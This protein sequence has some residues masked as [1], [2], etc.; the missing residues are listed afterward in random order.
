MKLSKLYTN[1]PDLFEP[2]T[3]NSGLSVVLAEIRLPE[4]RKKDTHNLGKTTLGQL[5]DFGLLAGRKPNFFLF[6]HSE[7]FREFVFFLEIEILDSSFVTVRRSVEH[8]SRIA[9]KRHA[10]PGMDLTDLP[11]ASWDHSDVPF[12]KAKKLLDGM[13]DL[14]DLKPWSYRKVVG[15]LVRSQ[16]DFEHVF[17]LRKFAAAHADWKPFLAHLLGFDGKLLRQHYAKEEELETKRSE[18]RVIERELG[19]SIADLSKIEGM[20]LL[21]QKDAEKRQRLLDDFDFRQA[22]KRQTK[23]VVDELDAKIAQLNAERYSLSQAKKKITASLADDEILFEPER[24]AEVFEEVG[25]LFAGQLKKDFEQLIAFN[26]AIT[27]ER[28]GYLKEELSEADSRLKE[29]NTDLQKLGKRRADAL[30]FLS[31]EDVF[32]KYKALTDELVTLRADITSLVRQRGFLRRLQDLRAQIRSLAEEKEHLQSQ[33]EAD[34]ERQNSEP[35]SLFSSVRVFFSEV[36]EEVID[37]KALLSVSPNQKG[38]LDFK[39]EI[40]DDSGNATSAD[41]GNTYR[42]LLCVA[43]DLAVSR[44]HLPGRY[45]RFLFHDGV[46]ESLDDR[47]KYNLLQVMRSCADLGIQ[48]IITVIDSDLPQ[49]TGTEDRFFTSDDVVLRLHD[50]GSGGRLFKMRP[51]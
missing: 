42:K 34:V 19:G 24:A 14:R 28:G 15:Y 40:L 38:H 1:R 7:L 44:A 50:E 10:T 12:D 35:E 9:F 41:L 16:Y 46:L 31:T 33:I 21:K 22:D 43:F 30:S 2:L 32:A 18:E 20:L 37:R 45:P 47:K 13:L 6:R 29:L 39:A 4:N 51:W 36:V 26:R 48:H 17:Y 49:P 8:H 11:E 23:L 27:E 3:F 5:I 25:V